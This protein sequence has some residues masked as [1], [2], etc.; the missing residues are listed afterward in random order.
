MRLV[1]S[2]AA[3]GFV[4][5]ELGLRCCRRRAVTQSGHAQ[6]QVRARLLVG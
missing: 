1:G 4:A 2:R 6:A 5:A 3:P